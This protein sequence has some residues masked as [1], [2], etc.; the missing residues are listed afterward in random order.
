MNDPLMTQPRMSIIIPCLNEAMVIAR[1]LDQVFAIDDAIEVLVSDGGSTD[2][3]DQLLAQYPIVNVLENVTTRSK[4]LNAAAAMANSDILLFLHADTLLP[5]SAVDLV[6]KALKDPET[7][8][9]SFSLSFD[10]SHPFLRFYSWVSRFNLSLF[11]YGDQGLFIR[12]KAF[13]DLGGFADLPF[14]EDLEIQRRL[15]RKGRFIKLP[16]AT[17][18]SARRFLNQGVIRQQLRNIC[19]V[20]AFYAGVSPHKLIRYYP[21]AK[22]NKSIT[23]S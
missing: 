18:T 17:L 20:L 16:Q 8:A 13:N 3:T 21:F 22:N 9:G 15:R 12:K 11:T 4:G 6:T 19:L 7:I 10:E 2:Q 5:D 14:M 1:T 23:H